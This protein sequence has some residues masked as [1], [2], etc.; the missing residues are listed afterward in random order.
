MPAL[1][2]RSP[3]T[4][5]SLIDGADADRCHPTAYR[6]GIILIRGIMIS[7]NKDTVFSL[8]VT[9]T[10]SSYLCQ[11]LH[12]QLETSGRVPCTHVQE[13][14]KIPCNVTDPRTVPVQKLTCPFSLFDSNI[15]V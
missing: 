5:G 15:S 11:T 9:L 1:A 8:T 7:N 13:I 2:S 4:S 10:A 6:S 12:V 14:I 3:R